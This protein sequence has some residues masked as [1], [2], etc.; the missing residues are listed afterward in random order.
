M[1]R[2]ARWKTLLELLVER[3]RLDVEEAAAELAVSAATIRRD[4]DQLAE[5]QMLVRTRGGAVVHGVSYE[6]PLRYKTARHASEKQRI[7]KAVAGLI[8]PGEAV[9]LTG[10]TTT[11]EVARALAVRGDLASGS[12]ALTIVTNALNIANELAVRPQFKIVLTGGVA[13]PQSY[14]LVGPLADAVLAQITIDVAVLGVVALDAEH[15]AAA[16]DEAEAAINRLLCE[17]AARVIV[18]ADSSKLGRRAFARIC[19][20][21]AVDTLVTDA[22]AA[23]ETVRRLEEQGLKVFAV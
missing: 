23:P 9:G 16:H 1:S 22:A 11:T 19:A 7:A 21:D 13:R 6:L 10:G 8:A 15:G 5:Q 17:R 4:F 18:A 20:A 14:E 2:D 3:G 12:P